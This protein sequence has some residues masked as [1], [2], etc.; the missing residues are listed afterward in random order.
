MIKFRDL[1]ADEVECRVQSVTAKGCTLLLY[2]NARCDMN[3]L[4]ETVGSE[5]WQ[6]K[7]YDCK[8]NL[9]CEIGIY[10]DGIGWVWK[11]DCGN[12]SNMQK[13]KGEASDS[14]KRAGFNWGIGRELYTSP[15]LYAKADICNININ[16]N[17]N[18]NHYSCSDKFVVT[19]IKVDNKVITELTVVDKNTGK[20]VY[21]NV[22]SGAD[23][24]RHYDL[25]IKN[26]AAVLAKNSD[27]T[28][29]EWIKAAQ[30]KYK[31][32]KAQSDLLAKWVK[33]IEQ[34]KEV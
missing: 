13:E 21:S 28:A 29:G 6:R 27:K 22:N 15:F 16:N 1:R 7:H 4:D 11:G 33:E 8:G 34:R 26:Y 12:E 20:T 24:Q 10:V 18:K 5:H 31:T 14:F 2:K 3:I 19:H 17:N 30:A 25:E 23:N 32:A 9:F